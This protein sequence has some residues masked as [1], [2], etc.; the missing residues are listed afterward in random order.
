MFCKNCGREIDDKAAVCVYC[1]VST[2]LPLTNSG[3]WN[4]VVA[5]LL[6]LFLG[7]LGAHRFYT[8]HTGSAVL[9]L[10]LPF[11]VIGLIISIPCVFI[12]FINI[13]CG[14]FKTADGQDLVK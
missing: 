12:D 2:G 11:T 3:N 14:N 9:Q 6:C 13:I 4:W 10:V 5:L 8:G 1:G 7:G